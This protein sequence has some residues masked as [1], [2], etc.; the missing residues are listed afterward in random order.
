MKNQE[1]FVIVGGITTKYFKLNRGNC[2]G[3]LI[4]AFLFILVFEIL[5]LLTKENT[6][7]NESNNFDNCDLYY[8]YADD[9]TFLLKDIFSHFSGLRRNLKK[10]EIA[11]I[12]VLK[13][14]KVVI[15]SIK[16]VDLVLHAIRLLGTHFSC[17]KK[18]EEERRFCL[19]IVNIQRVL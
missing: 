7:I 9:T 13:G 3:D 14:V 18:L 19:I 17:D 6:R 15:C 2:Q 1:S 10:C 12:G 8:A 11:G 16:C 4:S 5:F